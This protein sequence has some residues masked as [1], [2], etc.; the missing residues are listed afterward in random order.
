MSQGYKAQC[1][2]VLEHVGR[3][4]AACQARQESCVMEG[5]HLSINAIVRL[6]ARHPSV[7]PFLVHISNETKHRERF[8][9]SPGVPPALCFCMSEVCKRHKLVYAQTRRRT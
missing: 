1:E 2:S 6:M 8:A 5:V 4:V 7:L 9:V 3:L